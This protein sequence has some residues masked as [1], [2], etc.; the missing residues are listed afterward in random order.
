MKRK[1]FG[2]RMTY[3]NG[4]LFG[5]ADHTFDTY[6]K[7]EAYAYWAENLSERVDYIN[8]EPVEFIEKKGE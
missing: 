4:K 2:V 1:I 5:Y 7:A 3:P 6:E 8:Y